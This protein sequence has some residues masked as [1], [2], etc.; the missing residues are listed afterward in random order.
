MP[1]E[2]IPFEDFVAAAGS[3]HTQFINDL[4]SFLVEQNCVVNIKEAKS[5]YVVS[6]I[7]TPTKQT[8][9]NYVFR[10][11]GPMLRIYAD[12][13]AEYM[14]ILEGWPDSMKETVRKAG[15]CKRLL[16]PSACNPRCPMGFDFVLEG[17]RQQ[18]CRNNAF[19]FFLED[20]TKPYLLEIMK[21]ELSAQTAGR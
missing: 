6:Y 11:K 8:V 17:E 14:G 21:Q 1:K 19:M 10:K 3:A 12:S 15:P 16:D 7:H 9:C 13:I 18:K 5:G 4:H 2:T 20:S